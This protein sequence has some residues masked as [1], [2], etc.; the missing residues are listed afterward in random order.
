MNQGFIRVAAA[1]PRIRAADPAYNRMQTEE[2]LRGGGCRRSKGFLGQF[3]G[4]FVVPEIPAA[5]LFLQ[6]PL[7]DAAKRE[8]A[9]LDR[10]GKRSGSSGIRRDFPGRGTD[11]STM[12]WRP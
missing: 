4:A 7:L 2:A 9:E 11:S 12:S 8:L 5:D 3:P 6:D 10:H 1:T